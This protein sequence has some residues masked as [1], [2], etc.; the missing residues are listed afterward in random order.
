MCLIGRL[1]MTDPNQPSQT[2]PQKRYDGSP[3]SGENAG[4]LA[5]HKALSIA[6]GTLIVA[7]VSVM[8]VKAEFNDTLDSAKQAC[9]AEASFIQ[10]DIRRA[11]SVQVENHNRTPLYYMND[12]YPLA[13]NMSALCTV[14]GFDEN[15]APKVEIIDPESVHSNPGAIKQWVYER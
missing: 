4:R 2:D 13:F 12:I 1:N 7:A 11:L 3:V 6:F 15:G 8:G 10:A 5:N 9:T 14:S